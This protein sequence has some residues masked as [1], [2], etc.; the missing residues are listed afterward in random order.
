MS[1]HR[2]RLGKNP[3][4]RGFLAGMVNPLPASHGL[5]RERSLLSHHSHQDLLE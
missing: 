2:V 1:T 3:Y 5:H 4:V